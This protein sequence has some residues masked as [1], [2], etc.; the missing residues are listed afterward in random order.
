M[1]LCVQRGLA[2]TSGSAVLRYDRKP[3]IWFGTLGSDLEFVVTGRVGF[4]FWHLGND[5]RRE[6]C[7]AKDEGR[8]AGGGTVP[9]L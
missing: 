2:T 7:T 1:G 3:P 5:G 4:P 9:D 8:A 6:R